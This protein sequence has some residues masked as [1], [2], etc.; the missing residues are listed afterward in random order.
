[1]KYAKALVR[2]LLPSQ[3]EIIA[4]RMVRATEIAMRVQH[5]NIINRLSSQSLEDSPDKPMVSLTSFPARLANVHITIES[6][7]R[8]SEPPGGVY[9]WLYEGE[10][11]RSD[12]PLTLRRLEQR[13][14]HIEFV[15]ENL[16]GAKKLIYAARAFPE[17]TIITADDDLIYPQ[18][19]LQR[20]TA[21]S[22]ATPGAVICHRGHTIKRRPDGCFHR[23]WD[24]MR[25]DPGGA[26]PSL[27]LLPTGVAGA[28]YP[29]GAL[30]PQV[31]DTELMHRLCPTADDIWFKAMTLLNGVKSR[32]VAEQ[33]FKPI[34]IPG[35]Q[36]QAL[37]H[38]NK[39]ANDEQIEAT[40]AHFGLKDYFPKEV[41]SGE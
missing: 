15:P 4:T 30:N 38:G 40:F 41:L 36:E 20:L 21:A 26:E 24:C 25:T 17:R 23:Y 14:L 9:L 10:A 16:R 33:N 1:M 34:V 31:F 11:K 8:Q 19:W 35:S 2:R 7:F 37:I 18:D 32:R 39:H 6:I 13:G 12:L 29:P 5:L 22:L 27:A 3:I 28:L